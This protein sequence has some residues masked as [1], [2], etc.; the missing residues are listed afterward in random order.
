M[1]SLLAEKPL[2]VSLMLGAIAAALF[3]GW[4][5]SGGRGLILSTLGVVALIPG[6]WFLA[7]ALTTDRERIEE[8]VHELAASL[9]ANDHAAVVDRLTDPLLKTRAENELENFQ[10]TLARVNS[11]RRIDVL[12]GNSPLLANVELTAKVDVRPRSAGTQNFRFVRLLKLKMEKT[13]VTA[14]GKDEWSIADYAHFPITGK[15]D[16]YSQ[17]FSGN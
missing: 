5:Q 8:V 12:E 4:L 6:A 9:E 3:I 7:D 14:D 2:T 17:D 15:P 11:M 1:Y 16:G 10:F 13:G